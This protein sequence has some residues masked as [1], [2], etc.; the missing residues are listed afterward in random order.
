VAVAVVFRRIRRSIDEL[1]GR[2]TGRLGYIRPNYAYAIGGTAGTTILL[3]L[4]ICLR[5]DQATASGDY[6]Q[7]GA[8]GVWAPPPNPPGPQY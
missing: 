3:H 4:R 5:T 7:D 1:S 8:A 2:T 6:G